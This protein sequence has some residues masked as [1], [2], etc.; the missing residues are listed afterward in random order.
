MNTAKIIAVD[1][2]YKAEYKSAHGCYIVKI[3][4]Y[5]ANGKTPTWRNITEL[6]CASE[7]K[8]KI[9]TSKINEAFL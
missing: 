9:L 6:F 7:E 1:R 8:A 3:K 4:V 5:D 2:D